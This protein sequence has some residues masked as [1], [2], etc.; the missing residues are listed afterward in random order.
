MTPATAAVVA[1][2]EAAAAV[3]RAAVARGEEEE[4]GRRR[5]GARGGGPARAGDR[6]GLR[7]AARG[8]GGATHAT[9]EGPSRA[10]ATRGAVARRRVLV[11]GQRFVS[12]RRARGRL[13]GGRGAR[14]VLAHAVA[15]PSR[16]DSRSARRVRSRGKI[17]RALLAR[18]VVRSEE[19]ERSP[20]AR[21]SDKD[22]RR[23]T[24]RGGLDAW[25]PTTRRG[26]VRVPRK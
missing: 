12:R 11:R 20:I 17:R 18:A 6:A 10:I 19:A 23:E 2:T 9:P 22:E 26:G 16:D 7:N 4:E 14:R 15:P 5:R 8:R 1:A 25:A 3:S 24:L 13:G 21:F